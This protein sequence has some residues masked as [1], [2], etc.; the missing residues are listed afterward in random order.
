VNLWHYRL[1]ISDKDE[2]HNDITFLFF[3]MMGGYEMPN[4]KLLFRNK[5][6]HKYCKEGIKYYFSQSSER[7][8]DNEKQWIQLLDETKN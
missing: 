7:S 4:K 5:T 2:N 6:V 3:I 8:K 1:F